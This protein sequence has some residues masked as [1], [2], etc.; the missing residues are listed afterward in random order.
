[1][2]FSM[3]L[4]KKV[5]HLESLVD[6]YEAEFSYLNKILVKCGFSEGIA[7]LK[8]SAEELL[9]ESPE[10]ARPARPDSF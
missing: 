6:H 7:T 9:K 4:N 3:D 10:K 5:A 8:M 2:E 1:M